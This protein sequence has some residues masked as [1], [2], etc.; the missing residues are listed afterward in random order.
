M[1]LAV[2]D[3]ESSSLTL[4]SQ[5]LGDSRGW[6]GNITPEESEPPLPQFTNRKENIG[7]WG[8]V[9]E[10]NQPCVTAQTLPEEV[11]LGKVAKMQSRAVSE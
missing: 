4:C 1:R 11:E 3:L 2:G 8:D 9:N 5:L 7:I 10:W 6:C